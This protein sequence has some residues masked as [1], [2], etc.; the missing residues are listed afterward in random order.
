MGDK[1]YAQRARDIADEFVRAWTG[2]VLVSRREAAAVAILRALKAVRAE[3]IAEC[4]Q[5]IH[6][7]GK[8]DP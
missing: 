6:D 8:R 3:V 7:K 2:E 5:D 1:S 4:A